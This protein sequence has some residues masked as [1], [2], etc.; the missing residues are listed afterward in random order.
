MGEPIDT[1]AS[2]D[3]A[4]ETARRGL[5]Q[6]EASDAKGGGRIDQAKRA[7]PEAAEAAEQEASDGPAGRGLAR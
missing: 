7:N 2:D 3:K 6:A 5:E 1:N 4:T